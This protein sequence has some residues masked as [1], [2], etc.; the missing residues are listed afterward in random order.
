[1][2]GEYGIVIPQGI[3]QARKAVPRI[4]EDAENGLSDLFRELLAGLYDRLVTLD[5]QVASF[6]K[7]IRTLCQQSE[8]CQRVAQVGGVGPLIATAF[9]SS[10]GDAQCFRH[11]RQV[12][13][14]VGLVPRQ[15]S[16]GGKALLLWISKRGDRYLRT[17]LIQ[18][19]RT[20]VRAAQCKR[21]SLSRWINALRARRGFNVA[22]VAVANKNVRVMWA[23]LTRGQDYRRPLTAED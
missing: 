11:G 13:A 14:W 18:G 19:A 16:T 4:V 3:E 9:V 22:A 8:A 21:D 20:V 6:D 10:I 5:E 15:C 17:L 23:L 2:L 12:S 1:M 7:K